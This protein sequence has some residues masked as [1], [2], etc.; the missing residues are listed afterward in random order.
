MSAQSNL[1]MVLESGYFAVTGEVGP[2]QGVDTADVR[3]KGEM[4]RDYCDAMNI[5]DNQ[6]AVVRMSSIATGI[7]LRQ[8]GLDPVVQ[9]VCRDRNRLA[10]QSDVLGAAAFDIKNVL[11]LSGDHQSLGN[12]PESKNVHDLDSIQLLQCLV[13][14]REGRF[15]NGEPLKTDPPKLFIGAAANPFAGPLEYRVSRLAKKVKAGAE[16]IQT[17]P[18]FDMAV[19]KKFMADLRNMGLHEKTHILAGII[20]IKSAAMAKYMAANVAGVV[21]PEEVIQRMVNATRG[22][23]DKE[24]KKKKWADEGVKIACE[25]IAQVQEI[26]G[27]HGVHIMAVAWE[28]IIPEVVTKAGINKRPKRSPDN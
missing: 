6:S 2:K 3:K 24:Q 18:V 14:L 5:T 10:I 7:I 16:F 21:L 8:M 23:E 1:Q 9:I 19:F 17:Q 26:K 28:E 15:M 25:E 4:L 22:I 27:V 12:H 11:A 13:G 20:P